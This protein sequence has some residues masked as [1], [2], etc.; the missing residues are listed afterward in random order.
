MTVGMGGRASWLVGGVCGVVVSSTS[1]FVGWLPLEESLSTNI[2]EVS[3]DE[4]ADLVTE[5]V[6][7]PRHLV[8]S[9]TL[10]IDLPH[11][12]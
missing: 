4:R 7:G 2:Q 12:H 10:A 5:R 6:E 11:T 1:M 9:Q 3:V 8:C